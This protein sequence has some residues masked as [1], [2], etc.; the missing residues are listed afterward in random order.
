MTRSNWVLKMV[1]VTSLLGSGVVSAHDSKSKED[2][3]TVSKSEGDFF[4]CVKMKNTGM[5]DLKAR[6]LEECNV[7]KP[8][9]MAASDVALDSSLM[10][11]CQHK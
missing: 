5:A 4:R 7:N 11:C 6:I 1:L 2:S 8:W 10:F 9:S 3:G